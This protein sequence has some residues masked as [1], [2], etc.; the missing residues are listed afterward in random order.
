MKK[1]DGV[2][3]SSQGAAV[4]QDG[5]NDKLAMENIATMSLSHA[6]KEK[7]IVGHHQI[8]GDTF[9]ESHT[10]VINKDAVDEVV[11]TV[12]NEV[13]VKGENDSKAMESVVE[14][15]TVESTGEQDVS[16]VSAVPVTVAI[17][18]PKSESNSD[19]VD[20]TKQTEPT[21]ETEQTSGNKIDATPVDEPTT[22]VPALI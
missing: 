5:V 10:A 1:H 22:T 19:T 16:T 9:H 14:G 12:A 6:K 18:E 20:S 11:V 2:L 4:Y 21:E 13:V 15:T 7:L 8:G 3:A 17:S